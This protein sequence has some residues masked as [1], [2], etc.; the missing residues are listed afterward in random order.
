M[1]KEF[2]GIKQKQKEYIIYAP[3]RNTSNWCLKN[4][5]EC[6]ETTSVDNCCP[7]DQEPVEFAGAFSG[8]IGLDGAVCSNTLTLGKEAGSN[9]TAWSGMSA[10]NLLDECSLAQVAARIWCLSTGPLSSDRVWMISGF[11]IDPNGDA[12]PFGPVPMEDNCE[13][14]YVS[15]DVFGLGVL[16]LVFDRPCG[17]VHT[18]N[19][20][21]GTCTSV[22]GVNGV[23]E[24]LV[25][26]QLQC[27]SCDNTGYAQGVTYETTGWF[28]NGWPISYY[29]VVVGS[30]PATGFVNV[31]LG[32]ACTGA[33]LIGTLNAPGCMDINLLSGPNTISIH[34]SATNPIDLGG[35]FTWAFEGA[36][37]P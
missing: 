36:A 9:P 32:D 5:D 29:R 16:D 24:T 21:D 34:V 22:C 6:C 12:V 25:D 33:T 3:I 10:P 11:W 17:A 31:F 2:V 1:A 4:P 26:C 15:I 35:S 20:V 13:N 37:C 19:C 23:Y 7:E 27:G 18:Y 14:L 30:L 8:P 28:I